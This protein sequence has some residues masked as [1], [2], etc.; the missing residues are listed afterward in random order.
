MA[1]ATLLLSDCAPPVGEVPAPGPDV[2]YAIDR[3]WHTDIGLP[4]DEIS[5]RLAS[6]QQRFPGAR[7][8]TF[9]FGERQYLLSRQVTLGETLSA[10]LPSQSA[11]LVTG[12][13]ATPEAAFGP[14]HVVA[15]HVSADGLARI[16][17]AI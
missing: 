12:L 2:V 17:A 13:V 10:L 6:L 5:V 11:L 1:L 9:G 4:I 7:F 3:G 8:L 15:L 16:D 14:Q